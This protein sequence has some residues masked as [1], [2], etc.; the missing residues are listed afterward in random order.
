MARRKLSLFSRIWNPLGKTLK[1][2]GNT[3]RKSGLGVG[4]IAK[5]AVNT[6]KRI[7]KN[8][9]RRISKCKSKKRT[10]KSSRR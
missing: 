2:T 4:S 8:A 7:G 3:V 5:T 10:R 6:V 1:V 9:I